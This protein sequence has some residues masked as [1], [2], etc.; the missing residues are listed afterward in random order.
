MRWLPASYSVTSNGTSHM[1]DYHQDRPAV[2]VAADHP[3]RPAIHVSLAGEVEEALYRWVEV[4]AEE[5]GVPCQRVQVTGADVVVLAYAAAR[6]SRLGVGVGIASSQVAVHEFHMPAAQPA[7]IYE[8]KDNM[9]HI[10]RL[11]GSNAARLVVCMPLRFDEK[12]INE[13]EKT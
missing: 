7:L 6:S 3:N 12:L 11:A 5:E 10:C 9:K 13:G 1:L 8:T 2:H 4:G